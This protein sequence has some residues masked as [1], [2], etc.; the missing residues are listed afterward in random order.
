MDHDS[1]GSE[2]KHCKIF[3]FS[4]KRPLQDP[5]QTDGGR[6]DAHDL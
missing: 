2:I 6:N 4:M 5:L 1:P 3:L